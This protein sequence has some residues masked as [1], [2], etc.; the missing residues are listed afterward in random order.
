MG[1][2]NNTI[3]QLDPT[4]IENTLLISTR[5]LILSKNG[6]MEHSPG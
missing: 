3:D 1:D 2:W 6:T 4:D 5:I